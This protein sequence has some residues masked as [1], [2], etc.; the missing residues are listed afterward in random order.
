MVKF[1]LTTALPVALTLQNRVV[2]DVEEFKQSHPF[3]GRFIA[4]RGS[5]AEEYFN[6]MFMR[7]LLTVSVAERECHLP[8]NIC[9][10]AIAE[11]L[12]KYASMVSN[13]ITPIGDV[14][15]I[16]E[17]HE[18]Q[19]PKDLAEINFTDVMVVLNWRYAS[20]AKIFYDS[21]GDW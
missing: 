12:A 5:L 2:C 18:K 6:A 17:Y 3:F 20:N 21:M 8:D 14:A 10:Y 19:L 13:A 11:P 1:A 15:A 9:N 7:G 16:K 4:W